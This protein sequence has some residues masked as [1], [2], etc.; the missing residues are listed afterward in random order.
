MRRNVSCEPNNTQ[1]IIS[2]IYIAKQRYSSA[3]LFYRE[4]NGGQLH[5]SK[6][7]KLK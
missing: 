2:D 6:I 4:E 3:K 1:T 7:N 5:F